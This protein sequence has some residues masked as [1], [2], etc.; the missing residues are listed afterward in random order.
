MSESWAARQRRTNRLVRAI[1]DYLFAQSSVSPDQIYGL[2]K[3][4]WITNSYA[5][6]HAAY[7]RS[8]KIPA[9]GDVFGRDYSD[10]TLR[11]VAANVSTIL[12]STAAA[13]LVL[14]HTGFTNFYQAYRN[15][16]REWITENFASLLPLFKAACHLETDEQGLQLIR[17]IERLPR[18][19]KANHEEQ[20]MRPEYLLTPAFFALDPRMRFPLING[21]EGV[22]TLLAA[23]NVTN[24]PLTSQYQSMIGLYGRG[25]I[26]G[27]ADLDQV[28]HD[29]PDFI[30]I[31]GASPT[32]QL[33]QE[34][35]TE[36]S[37]LPLK[38]ESDIESLQQARLIV[39]KRLHN[40][41]TNK[42]KHRLSD[43]TL[44]EGCNKAAQ[45]DTLVENYNGNGDDL[46]I[47]VKSLTEAA[48]VR[49]A[50]GQL[51]A[52]WFRLRGDVKPHLAIL[53]PSEP[54]AEL[55]RLLEWLDIGILWFSGDALET[56]SHWLD[57]LA[58]D[59]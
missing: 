10:S 19:P 36:G 52:Y 14:S 31:S 34:R 13:D 27:A 15:T 3:L 37:E 29:L 59:G 2:C 40:K 12:R 23:L 48:Y 26:T 38:D 7:I 17:K 49:M 6:D 16:A 9:L 39:N 56:C 24:A 28:G 53:L 42:L 47:E 20:L 57:N 35:P 4:T 55:K 51:F 21:N 43:Y 1:A 18:V 46:L 54:D 5:G 45:F 44:L 25:G 33:L 11:E 58:G 41:L 22:K 50:I 30:E 32:K 8:T